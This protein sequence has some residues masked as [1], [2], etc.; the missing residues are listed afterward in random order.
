[1]WVPGDNG[2]FRWTEA[3]KA[4]TSAFSEHSVRDLHLPLDGLI[5]DVFADAEY[6]AHLAE[7]LTK[8]AVGLA[9]RD[10]PQVVVISHGS[11]L[12]LELFQ[13]QAA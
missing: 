12:G 10:T 1:M 3:E 11:R 6:R 2:A 8:R 7:V 5:E 13:P 9:A 4:L